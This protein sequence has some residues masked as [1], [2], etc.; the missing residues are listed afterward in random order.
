MECSTESCKNEEFEIIFIKIICN[1]LE[2]SFR[3]YKKNKFNINDFL[4]LSKLEEN[5][6]D[7]N[8][9][10]LFLIE[11]I[12][13]I[14][15]R[16]SFPSNYKIIKKV[17]GIIKNIYSVKWNSCTI[18]F[19]INEYIE[20]SE[21]NECYFTRKIF[22]QKSIP[23][24]NN[25][26]YYENFTFLECT[27]EKD[28]TIGWETIGRLEICKGL[29]LDCVF[30]NNLKLLNTFFKFPFFSNSELYSS[31]EY[32]SL[33]VYPIRYIKKIV[34]EDCIFDSNFTINGIDL[35]KI[36]IKNY[37]SD[38][39]Y[40]VFIEDLH[41]KNSKFNNKF[42]LKYSL[43][44]N[45]D[46]DNSNVDGIFDVYKSSFTKAKFFKSIFKDFAA[47]EYAVF[48]DGG[49]ENIT[50]FIY[51]TF[52][53]FSN[54]R[55]TKFKSGL[56]FS[57]AN[58]KQEPNFLNTDINLVGTDRETLRIIKNSFEKSNNKIEANRFFVHEMNAYRKEIRVVPDMKFLFHK[59]K[60]LKKSDILGIFNRL[61]VFIK[62]VGVSSKGC[63][64]PKFICFYKIPKY[65]IFFVKKIFDFLPI[66]FR[67]IIVNVNYYIS[68]FGASYIRPL[69]LLLVSVALYTYMY[70]QYK[71][72]WRVR[73]YA[74]PYNLDFITEQ[75]NMAARNFLPFARFI[76]EKSGFEF[77]SLMFYVLFGV[78]TWQTIVAVKRHT[79]N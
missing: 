37:L 45:I 27:F 61:I 11:D 41:I 24:L 17:E 28:V 47:F 51:T 10:S 32:D 54:F 71:K 66:F 31:T 35:D 63:R 34:I 75:L 70:E 42:E 13:L 3:E 5:N 20:R 33:C 2:S 36:N 46:F 64:R 67:N 65:I 19:D 12:E 76:S 73:E 38:L 50:D 77:A 23:S 22:L 52:K 57:S 26:P 44:E 56:N 16:V 43:V 79:Q 69:T 59:V 9:E 29:F 14:I 62:S 39:K 15:D 4:I 49:K 40:S 8:Y 21:F 58:I 68:G 53:D 55:N 6:L 30:I 18:T 1:S 48:G 74:L 25:K 60:L 78:L 7:F 72:H